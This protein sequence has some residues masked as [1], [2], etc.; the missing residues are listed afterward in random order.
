[1]VCSTKLMEAQQLTGSQLQGKDCLIRRKSSHV[2]K[3]GLIS[4]NI[5]SVAIHL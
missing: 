1:L 5:S 2:N 4:C 3:L